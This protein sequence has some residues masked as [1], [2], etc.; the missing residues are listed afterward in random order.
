MSDKHILVDLQSMP[1]DDIKKKEHLGM[2]E[3]FLKHIRDRDI[4]KLWKEFFESFEDVILLDKQNGYIYIKSFLYYSDAKLEN[5]KKEE[6]TKVILNSLP[7][8]D[9][10]HIMYTI[11]DGYI[12]QGIEKGI[13]I[14]KAERDTE[15][16]KSLLSK[17]IDHNIIS[18]ATGLSLGE[19]LKL[20]KSY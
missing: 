20:S 12:D 18:S 17:N 10:E 1:D 15:I 5:D 6:L 11:A 3:F 8:E 14:G 16:V 2:L 7:K 9:G 19:I 13:A 4:I